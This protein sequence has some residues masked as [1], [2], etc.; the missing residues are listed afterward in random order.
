MRAVQQQAPPATGRQG[1]DHDRRAMRRLT[2]DRLAIPRGEL[3]R[4]TELHTPLSPGSVDT[5]SD[6]LER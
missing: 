5:Q 1:G 6:F 2:A 3:A 4:T